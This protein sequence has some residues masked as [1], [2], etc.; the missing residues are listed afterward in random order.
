MFS[1]PILV[2]QH[3][4]KK[5]LLMVIIILK[6]IKGSLLNIA[7]NSREDTLLLS[8]TDSHS[9]IF[10]L[11]KMEVRETIDVEVALSQSCQK[12][13]LGFDSV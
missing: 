10:D 6:L 8:S 11:R 5:Y 1:I 3:L 4:M 7:I 9:K 2:G 13:M 12:S